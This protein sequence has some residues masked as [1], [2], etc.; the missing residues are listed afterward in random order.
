MQYD[1]KSSKGGRKAEKVYEVTRQSPAATGRKKTAAAP[2]R[3]Q[4]TKKL[5]APAEPGRLLP[6]EAERKY[7][8][9]Q[10]KKQLEMKVRAEGAAREAEPTIRTVKAREKKPFPVAALF[11][12]LMCSV[13]ALY[14]I[15][16][17]VK[18]S[19]YRSEVLKTQNEIRSLTEEKEEL[20]LALDKKNDLLLIEE[21]ALRYGMVRIDQ[22]SRYYITVSGED[23]IVVYDGD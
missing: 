18:L 22:L 4:S 8:E 3:P 14:M 16:N 20:Q 1:L 2:H 13:L 10:R 5:N 12:C 23:Q 7:L 19:E 11:L 9:E 15:Y 6:P 17:S 21:Y